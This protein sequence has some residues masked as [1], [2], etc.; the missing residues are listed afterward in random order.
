MKCFDIRRMP[1]T[2]DMVH[3]SV[4]RSYHVL[5]KVQEL[6]RQQTPARVILEVIEDLQS[7]PFETE[8][9]KAISAEEP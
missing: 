2:L 4:F 8:S 5:E 1:T 7:E 9:V 6:L 3:E